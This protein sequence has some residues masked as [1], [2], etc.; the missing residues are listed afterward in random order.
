MW[1]G[2][3][4]SGNGTISTDSGVLTNARSFVRHTL[5][6]WRRARIPRT[7]RCRARRA[8]SRWR[9]PRSWAKRASSHKASIPTA[10]VT[11]EKSGEAFAITAVHLDLTAR[12][13]GANQ[14]AF[15]KA[16]E[17]AKAG[18]PVSKLFERED[19]A[20]QE[21]RGVSDAATGVTRRKPP[22]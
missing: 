4:K 14:Q 12:I 6:K 1:N 11:L 9:C 5:R 10:T 15:E 7:D 19:H 18:C 17:N 3:L 21:A 8:A 20:R 13:P 16:A 22:E 2:D